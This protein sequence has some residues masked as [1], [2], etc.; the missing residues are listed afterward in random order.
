HEVLD[1]IADGIDPLAQLAS[2]QQQDPD[3]LAV[4]RSKRDAALTPEP[5]PEQSGNSQSVQPGGKDGTGLSFVIQEH[6]ARALHWD[7]RL[8]H[9]GVLVSWAV[10]KGPPLE[11]GIQRLAVMTEDHPL[12]YASF[13]GSIPKGQYGAGE[14]SIWDSGSCTIE[15]W[16][17]GKE[18]IAVLTGSREGGLGGVDRRFVLIQAAGM[19]GKD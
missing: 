9:D 15:K 8:E 18:V 6:H 13:E 3:R 1:R 11:P 10:P 14:V 16:R 2:G 4:Y 19:G 5:V 7:F 17:E 12:S